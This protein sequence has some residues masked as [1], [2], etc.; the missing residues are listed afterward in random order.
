MDAF[1]PAEHL[2]ASRWVHA[3]PAWSVKTRRVPSWHSKGGRVYPPTHYGHVRDTMMTPSRRWGRRR[4]SRRCKTRLSLPELDRQGTVF[5][6]RLFFAPT[7]MVVELDH[8][9]WGGKP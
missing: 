9:V 7:E 8:I 6:F 5:F 4:L 3:T 2:T 1:T